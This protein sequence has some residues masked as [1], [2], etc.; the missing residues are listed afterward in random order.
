MALLTVKEVIGEEEEE[1]E[2]EEKV[3]VTLEDKTPLEAVAEGWRAEY[4]KMLITASNRNSKIFH[5]PT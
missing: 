4:K 2:E 3:D 1:E 5:L